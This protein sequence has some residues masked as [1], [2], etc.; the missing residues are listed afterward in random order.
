MGFERSSKNEQRK[1][2]S[3]SFQFGWIFIGRQGRQPYNDVKNLLVCERDAMMER[4]RTNTARVMGAAAMAAAFLISI[5]IGLPRL[6]AQDESSPPSTKGQNGT[7]DISATKPCFAP[8]GEDSSSLLRKRAIKDLPE[9]YRLWLTEDVVYLSSEE[10]DCVFLNLKNDEE[11]EQFI[12]MF[13]QRRAPDPAALENDFKKEYYRRIVY[14]NKKFGTEIPGWETDRGRAYIKFGPPDG[15]ET[16][17]G[18]EPAGNAAGEGPEKYDHAWSRWHYRSIED[19]GE[20]VDLDF[21]DVAGTGDYIMEVP[22]EKKEELLR[23]EGVPRGFSMNDD[24]IQ[25]ENFLIPGHLA[26]LHDKDLD[27]MLV[28]KVIRADVYFRPAMEYQ[29]ATHATTVVRLTIDIPKEQLK[30]KDAKS[31]RRFEIL[32]RVSNSSGHVLETFERTG[33]MGEEENPNLPDPNRQMTMALR[34]GVYSL[35]IV[36][37]DAVSGKTGMLYTSLDVPRYDEIIDER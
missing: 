1:A 12:K 9:Y 33:E 10:E 16:H 3:F 28:A 14:A 26:P 37:K 29:K 7:I 32:G 21:V 22:S 2:L 36:V 20:N 31:P 27:A 25:I 18:G 30:R 19:V 17:V 35:E 5:P 15:I 4:N 6:L 11:R 8:N 13:W 34:P 23:P 24:E